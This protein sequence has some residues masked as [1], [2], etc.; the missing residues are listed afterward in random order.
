[1]KKHTSIVTTGSPKQS[2]T[3]CTIGFNGFLRDLPGDRAFLPPL[4]ATMREHRHQRDA[5]VEASGPHDFAVRSPVTRQLTGAASIASNPPF[6]TIA[7]RPLMGRTAETSGV[8]LPDGASRKFLA[9]ALDN[10]LLHC[11]GF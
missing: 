3:P 8:D 7:K 1:M 2:G 6:V 9:E 5:S 10:L 4:Q 11:P